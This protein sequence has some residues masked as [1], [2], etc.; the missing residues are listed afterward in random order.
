[1]VIVLDEM[2]GLDH[3]LRQLLDEQGHTVRLFEDLPDQLDR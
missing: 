1:V 2:T 3:G